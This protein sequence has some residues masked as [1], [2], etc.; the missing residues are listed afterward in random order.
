MWPQHQAEGGQ[1]VDDGQI[2]GVH[3]DP[4]LTAPLG[5]NTVALSLSSDPRTVGRQ[6]ADQRWL[7]VGPRGAGSEVRQCTQSTG[8]FL[9]SEEGRGN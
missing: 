8:C 4:V 9:V 6:D 3:W 5:G 1:E 7:R 2:V